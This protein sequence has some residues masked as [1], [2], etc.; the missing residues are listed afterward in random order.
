LASGELLINQR[1]AILIG[2]VR[3][4]V[5]TS[6][7]RSGFIGNIS[8]DPQD[9]RIIKSFTKVTGATLRRWKYEFFIMSNALRHFL[10][11]AGRQIEETN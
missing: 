8:D 3:H 7:G 10:Y 5:N 1:N 11:P 6:A 4:A 2:V 9:A